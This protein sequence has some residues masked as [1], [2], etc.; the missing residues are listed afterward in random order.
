MT[1]LTVEQRVQRRVSR[2]NNQAARE[3][4][5]LAGT[6]AIEP[7]LTTPD[8]QLAVLERKERA[9]LE[10][11]ER[12]RRVDV[13]LA[14]TSAQLRSEVEA[15]L[16]TDDMNALDARLAEM[17]VRWPAFRQP[18]YQADYWRVKLR[19]ARSLADPGGGDDE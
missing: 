5:L 8:E 18:S 4:P 13:M 7:F 16:S 11:I 9:G 15:L 19:I 17:T 14:E 6:P 2:H 3:L 1:E 12:L 10:Y